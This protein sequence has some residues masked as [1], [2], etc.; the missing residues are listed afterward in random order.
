MNTITALE[1]QFTASPYIAAAVFF[2][3]VVIGLASF[4]DAL[5]RLHAFITKIRTE[6]AQ[7]GQQS[8]PQHPQAE[9]FEAL[10]RQIMHVGTVN[11]LPVELSK[12]RAFFIDADLVT[13]SQFSEFYAQWLDQP[14]VEQG[15]PVLVPSF[16]SSER[17][18]QLKAELN[19]LR[20]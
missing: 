3:V 18:T 8:L 14:F 15:T 6:W 1:E 17:I 19:D 12:L 20:L 11:N 5:D 16:F 7:R 13:K 2:V 4:T 10:K 9:Q